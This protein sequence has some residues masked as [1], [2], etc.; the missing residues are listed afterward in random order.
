MFGPHKMRDQASCEQHPNLTW[1]RQSREPASRV[2]ALAVATSIRVSP[3]S[4]AGAPAAGPPPPRVDRRY[5]AR[6][7][8]H[9][10][11]VVPP[12]PR[13]TLAAARIHSRPVSH[14]SAPSHT[15]TRRRLQNTQPPLPPAPSSPRRCLASIL[16][17]AAARRS[18]PGCVG[19][20]SARRRVSWT[21][22]GL[23]RVW[24]VGEIADP[25]RVSWTRD[26]L[27]RV[28]RVGEIADPRR[29]SWTRDGL[30]R[31][32]CSRLGRVSCS[33]IR[34]WQNRG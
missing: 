26:G 6:G 29:V 32:S 24:R 23:G 11:L 22:D 5:P 18:R 3:A 7:P 13:L 31:V 8:A 19:R 2:P 30:G 20:G 27:G 25:R 34:S 4:R 15:E 12:P 14:Q 16:P 9:R 28:W 33:R 1:H 17:A 10:R 21:R